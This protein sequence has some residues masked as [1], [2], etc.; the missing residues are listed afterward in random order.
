MTNRKMVRRL[1]AALLGGA[2]MMPGLAK[3]E[4]FT[5][6]V[7]APD[8]AVFVSQGIIPMLEAIEEATDKRVSFN[9]Y[10]GTVVQGAGTTLP[11][12]KSGAVDSGFVLLSPH[13][14]ALPYASL[15][16]EFA[17]VGSHPLAVMGAANE[18]FM[19]ACPE[20]LEDFRREGQEPTFVIASSPMIMACAKEVATADD[21]KGLRVAVVSAPERR[22]AGRLGMA[23]T[24]TKITDLATTMELGRADCA[25]IPMTWIRSYGLGDTVK[26]VI[27][28]P[29]GIASAGIP[30]TFTSQAWEKISAEDR[31]ALFRA[32]AYDMRRY[33]E[34]SY[35][36]PD[37][38]VREEQQDRIKME[39][40]DEALK[41]AWAAHSAAEIDELIA[42]ANRRGLDN[43]EEVVRRFAAIF[44]KW[45]TEHLPKFRDNPQAFDEIV[46]EQVFSKL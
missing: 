41:E 42:I 46:W 17:G 31:V 6:G 38:S 30:L 23:A 43:G 37:V 15:I 25:T 3:A 27:E 4:E 13:T 11:A 1:G 5:Y 9:G 32:L 44:E 8:R 10:Y 16:S 45:H 29:Q 7:G 19:T 28:M 18:A 40:G 36:E 33:V 34:K 22:W 21:L 39:P 35:L 24:S 14:S 26:S 12:L 20:C 2:L